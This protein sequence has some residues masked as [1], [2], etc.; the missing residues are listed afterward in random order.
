MPLIRFYFAGKPEG[1]F[2]VYRDVVRKCLEIAYVKSGGIK[3]DRILFMPATDTY[4]AGFSLESARN[5]IFLS[6]HQLIAYHEH[7]RHPLN[8][9]LRVTVRPDPHIEPTLEP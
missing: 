6:I 2:V 5:D 7:G 4:R 8:C 1:S 9:A 3:Y